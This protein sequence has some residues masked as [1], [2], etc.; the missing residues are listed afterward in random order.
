MT[1]PL[2]RRG[3]RRPRLGPRGA[4]R[5]LSP[6]MM[7]DIGLDPWPLRPHIPFYPLW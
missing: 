1:F 7:Q 5:G 3:A 4:V 6:R 2:F